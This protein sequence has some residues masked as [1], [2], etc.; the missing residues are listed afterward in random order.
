LWLGADHEM[1]L[2]AIS[3]LAGDRVVEEAV[4]QAIDDKP[5]EAI[6]GFSDLL[7]DG[8]LRRKCNRRISHCAAVLSCP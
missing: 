1:A 5:F 2:A 8:S 6:E 3:D 4:L 7:A